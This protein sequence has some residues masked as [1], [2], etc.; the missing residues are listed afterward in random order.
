MI[1]LKTTNSIAPAANE[2]ENGSR[3]LDNC[4]KQTPRNPAMTS[5]NP[6]NCPYLLNIK[7]NN[8]NEKPILNKPKCFERSYT[9]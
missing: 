8:K 9:K 5:T 4:T 6:L 2:S 1:S 7:L 3:Q